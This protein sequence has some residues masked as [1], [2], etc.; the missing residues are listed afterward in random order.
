MFDDYI[1]VLHSQ[2]RSSDTIKTYKMQLNKFFSWLSEANGKEVKSEEVTAIDAVEYRTY[3]Q[4]QNKKPATIN[5]ALRSIEA[6]CRWLVEEGRLDHNP[7]AKVKKVDQVQA[8]PKWLDKNEKY[9]LI[10]TACKEKDKRNTAIILTMLLAG[11]RASELTA[12]TPDDVV[13][14]ERKGTITV[15]AGKGNKWRVIPIPKELRECLGEYLLERVTA[16]WLFDS[17]RGDQLTYI[18][19]YQ[20]VENMGRKANIDKLTPHMLRHTYCHD[21]VSKGVSIEMVSKLAGHSKLETTMI[22]TQPGE[23]ELQAAVEKLSFS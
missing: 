17:Q 18:G 4:E 20:L 15:R 9:R 10:R 14:S 21:L 2:G 13:I 8:M 5:T 7:L 6:Y 19:L 23:Q 11:I 1:A 16:K 3:L 12:L 22:Y